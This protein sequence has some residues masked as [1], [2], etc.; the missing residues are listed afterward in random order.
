MTERSLR[1]VLPRDRLRVGVGSDIN[2][3]DRVDGQG[4]W[5]GRTRRNFPWA[6]SGSACD[7]ANLVDGCRRVLADLRYLAGSATSGSTPPL[8]RSVDSLPP[9]SRAQRELLVDRLTAALPD[10][11]HVEAGW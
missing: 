7:L 5:L 11:D 8:R 6:W 2:E 9:R 1:Q 4:R 3:M 10:V